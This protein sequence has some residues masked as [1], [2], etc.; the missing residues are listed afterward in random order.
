[1]ADEE[2]KEEGGQDEDKPNEDGND[3]EGSGG[4]ES[5]DGEAE[6][7]AKGG[8]GKLIIIIAAAAV[9]LI[10]I[11]LALFFLGFFG[12][13]EEAEEEASPIT[14]ESEDLPSTEDELVRYDE[15]GNP[16]I[17]QTIY[18]DMEE[19]IV[20]LNVGSNRPSF[21]KMTLSLELPGELHVAPIESKLPRIRDSFQIY[22]RELRTDDL[23]GS[24]GIYRLREELL[25]RINKIVHP[26]KVN[27]ILFKE[28]LIQ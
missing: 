20:N 11:P 12:G 21:L 28:I 14:K 16:I 19:F 25:L 24:A 23:Q 2:E 13:S 9:V 3:A 6:G 18:Y 4:A 17:E 1:M 22:L 27:D 15:D 10:S 8:K 7:E 5:E 26:A